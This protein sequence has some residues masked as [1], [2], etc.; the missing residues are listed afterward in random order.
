[1]KG[2]RI[3]LKTNKKQFN[4]LCVTLHIYITYHI[5]LQLTQTFSLLFLNYDIISFIL[6]F[7][8]S[9]IQTTVNCLSAYSQTFS[10]STKD[11]LHRSSR[12]PMNKSF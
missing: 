8:L 10:F 11:E 5:I 3:Y 6:I 9:L 2:K 12:R 4:R 1:M 7:F